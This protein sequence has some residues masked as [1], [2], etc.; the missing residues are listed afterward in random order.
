MSTIRTMLEV[1]AFFEVSM[2]GIATDSPSDGKV[3]PAEF[4]NFWKSCSDAE[5]EY[6]KTCK[7]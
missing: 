5:K 1:K 2:K 4:S 7:I 3:S 6:Y